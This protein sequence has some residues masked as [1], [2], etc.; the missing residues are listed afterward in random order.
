[1]KTVERSAQ[2]RLS[3][4]YVNLSGQPAAPTAPKVNVYDPGQGKKVDAAT[5]TATGI[6]Q[7]YKHD[8]TIAAA[9]P[10]GFWMVE[11]LDGTVVQPSLEGNDARDIFRVV[12]TR[13]GVHPARQPVYGG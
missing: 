10:T 1:V 9:D 5:P 7:E 6:G 4:I 12:E 11:W 13:A 8:L 2:I 3:H